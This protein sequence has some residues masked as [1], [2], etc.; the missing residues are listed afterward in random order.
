[1][2]VISERV[3]QM[4]VMIAPMKTMFVG[5]TKGQ[6]GGDT[7]GP[8][9]DTLEKI[10]HQG[11]L[12]VSL[13]TSEYDAGDFCKGLIFAKEVSQMLMKVFGD[14]YNKIFM[15]TSSGEVNPAIKQLMGANMNQ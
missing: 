6:A 5:M 8:F 3:K 7:A 2:P 1:M 15:P 11:A 12:I 10:V 14:Y 9:L 13:F 4:E